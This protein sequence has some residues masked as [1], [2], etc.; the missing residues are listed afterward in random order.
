MPSEPCGPGCDGN[1]RCSVRKPSVSLSVQ[2]GSVNDAY[3]AAGDVDGIQLGGVTVGSVTTGILWT[4]N[5]LTPI[6]FTGGDDDYGQWNWTQLDTDFHKRLK[7]GV[8]ETSVLNNTQPPTSISGITCLDNSYPYNL[9]YAANGTDQNEGDSPSEALDNDTSIMEIDVLDSFQDY[10]MYLPPGEDSAVV[11]LKR[12]KW[13]WQA[14]CVQS[15][16][17][18]ATSYKDAQWSFDGD[19]PDHPVWNIDLLNNALGYAP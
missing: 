15:G 1:A 8:W 6:G 14:K 12:I 2:I 3:G 4:G 11:P 9:W 7:G 10:M 13:F 5:V 19:F 17:L 16:G 18:W